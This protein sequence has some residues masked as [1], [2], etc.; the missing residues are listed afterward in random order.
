[1]KASSLI[2][3]ALFIQCILYNRY[4][5]VY[6]YIIWYGLEWPKPRKKKIS[7]YIFTFICQNYSVQ[8]GISINISIGL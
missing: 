4:N 3:F 2:N 6:H 8:T 7:L 5:I 1:M